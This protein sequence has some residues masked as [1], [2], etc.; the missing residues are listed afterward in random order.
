M[1]TLLFPLRH[2]GADLPPSVHGPGAYETSYAI[3][4]VY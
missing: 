4:S 3:E 2:V 1:W